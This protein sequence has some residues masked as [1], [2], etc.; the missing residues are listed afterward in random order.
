MAASYST[1]SATGPTD[2]LQKLV[3]WLVAQGWTSDASASYGSG[4]RAHLHRSGQYVNLRAFANEAANGTTGWG[5]TG[6]SATAGYGIGMYLGDGYSGAAAWNAQSGG[7]MDGTGTYRLGVGV[8]LTSAAIP[9]YPFLDDGSG[10]VTVIV[11]KGNGLTGHLGWG[12]SLAKTGY[13]SD[14]WYFYGSSPAYFTAVLGTYG[15]Y[16][17]TDAPAQVPMAMSFYEVSY[18]HMAC[19]FV[20]VDASVFAPRWLGLT[21]GT[22]SWQRNGYTG[23][24]GQS[25]ISNGTGNLEGNYGEH[26]T[27]TQL[28]GRSWQ[29]AFAGALLLPVHVFMLGAT[30]RWVPLGFPPT[31][32]WFNGVG[33]GFNSGQVVAIGGV[34]YLVFA[35]FAVKKLA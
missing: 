19:S 25:W 10:H 1:G 9:V 7:P 35:N 20:R 14:Y 28:I 21:D 31:V 30:S 13:T 16:Q 5:S 17:G 6:A 23:K 2:L 11:D 27:M 4:W 18:A 29:S 32:F 12:P 26:P 8:Y 33:H 15:P 3:T 22:T 34:N 24:F